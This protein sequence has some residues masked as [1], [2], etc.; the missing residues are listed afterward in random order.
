MAAEKLQ[1]ERLSGSD[2]DEQLRDVF[3]EQRQRIL[4]CL[5]PPPG[6]QVILCPSGSDAEYLPVA[7]AKALTSKPIVNGVTQVREIGAGSAPAAMGQYFSTHAPLTG[8]LANAQGTLQGFE[9]VNGVTLDARHRSGE[10]QD[11]VIAMTEFRDQALAQGQYPIV[12]GVFGGKTGMRDPTMPDSQLDEHMGVVDAC[13]GRFTHAEL[14]EWINQDSV[15]LFTGSKFYQGPPFCGAVLVSSRLAERLSQA[16]APVD[17]LSSGGLGGFL[18]DKE[19]PECL[20]SW[21]PHLATSDKDTNNMGLA[22]RW[23]AGLAGMEAL[24]H[25]PDEERNVA[26]ATWAETVT[27]QVN[28]QDMLHAWCVER[29]I[30]SIRAKSSSGGWRSMSELRDLYR[31]MSLN[32]AELVPEA[33]PEE[34]EALSAPAYIGQPVDVSETHAIVR[35]ALG[36]DSLLDY[37]EDPERTVAQ[38]GKVVRK[39]AAIAKHFDTLKASGK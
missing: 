22:L 5:N 16:D 29:S 8:P 6:T 20:S 11:A 17:M 19:L 21:G 1:Q 35:I 28:D 18:T 34:R 33:T 30:V 26:V 32:V 24:K 15:V 25:V 14:C 10:A 27:N 38:D 13:Q 39:L 23:E 4:D 36:V 9:G 12:H 7:M 37:L 31:W 3:A 2:V